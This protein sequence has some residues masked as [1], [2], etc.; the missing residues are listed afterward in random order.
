VF[1]KKIEGTPHLVG[2]CREV[3]SV[4]QDTVGTSDARGASSAVAGKIPRAPPCRP[5]RL[6][7][8]LIS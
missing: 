4:A 6:G 1:L 5:R 2:D 3:C 7:F 8:R